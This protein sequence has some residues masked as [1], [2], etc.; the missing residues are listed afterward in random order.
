MRSR[1]LSAAHTRYAYD[2]VL[3]QI[4]NI[5]VS[6]NTFALEDLDD[7]IAR[8]LALSAADASRLQRGGNRSDRRRPVAP[9]SR[10]ALGG[11]GCHLLYGRAADPLQRR[12]ESRPRRSRARPRSR[13]CQ[14]ELRHGLG[15]RPTPARERRDDRRRLAGRASIR[16]SGARDDRRL[17]FRHHVRPL[18]QPPLGTA[19]APA[20][21][22]PLSQAR[23]RTQRPDEASAPPGSRAVVSGSLRCSSSGSP[24]RWPGRSPSPSRSSC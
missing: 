20:R 17:R 7:S 2:T 23:L 13:A 11:G 6:K 14:R 15:A 10:S 24:T 12:V 8:A 1:K 4:C 16:R 21:G 22:A 5:T 3:L 18:A 9:A 19:L